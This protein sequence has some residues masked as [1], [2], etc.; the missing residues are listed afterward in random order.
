MPVSQKQIRQCELQMKFS[1]LF[2]SDPVLCLAIIGQPLHDFENMFDL[3][4]YGRFLSLPAFGL[5]FGA[6]RVVFTLRWPAV[7]FVLYYF[8][9]KQQTRSNKYAIIG[10]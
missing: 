8:E 5:T 2:L 1:F 9:L 7:D 3:C 10:A 6:C 4:T